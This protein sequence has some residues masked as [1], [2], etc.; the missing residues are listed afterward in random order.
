MPDLVPTIQI[1][2]HTL[3]LDRPLV[4]IGWN[5]PERVPNPTDAE[6]DTCPLI[7][8]CF[9]CLEKKGRKQHFGGEVMEVPICRDCYPYCDDKTV[10]AMKNFD[11]WHG[12]EYLTYPPERR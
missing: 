12:Y 4:E 9:C 8:R 10:G 6:M 2:F 11:R 5:K 7:F 1:T 3:R